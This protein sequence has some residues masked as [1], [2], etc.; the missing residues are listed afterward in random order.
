MRILIAEDDP[1]SHHMLAAVLQKWGHEVASAYTGAEAWTMLESPG[2]PR[3]AILDW[4][5]PQMDGVELVRRIRG[6]EELN[7]VYVIFLTSRGEHEDVAQGLD[8]GANDFVRKPFDRRELKAR[9]DVGCRVLHLQEALATRI[10]DLEKALAEVKVL[11]GLIPMC[12]GCKRIRDDTG[13][14]REV[15]EYLM[16]RTEAEFSHGLCPECLRKHYP[17]HYEA[18]EQKAREREA[19][20]EQD[21]TKRR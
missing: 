13:Y 21:T 18:I 11:R 7:G 2:S 9:V 6:R 1:T 20:R 4:M 19:G 5:M 8:A 10:I 14:W 17:A 12:A 16:S 15:E 3:F